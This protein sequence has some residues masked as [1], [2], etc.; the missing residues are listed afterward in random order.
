MKKAKPFVPA[1][2]ISIVLTALIFCYDNTHDYPNNEDSW[3]II[4]FT[5]TIYTV[6]LTPFASVLIAGVGFVIRKAKN[7]KLA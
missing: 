1:V 7:R 4:L 6:I 5:G 2:L 3:D